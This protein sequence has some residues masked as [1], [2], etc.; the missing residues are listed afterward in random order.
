[1]EV[2]SIAG[3]DLGKVNN[4]C[5]HVFSRPVFD[6][7]DFRLSAALKS[8]SAAFSKLFQNFFFTDVPP[9]LVSPPCSS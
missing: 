2:F 7:V 4:S 5:A 8:A 9:A 1:M 6:A 3:Q